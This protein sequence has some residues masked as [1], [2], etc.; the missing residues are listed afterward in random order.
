MAIRTGRDKRRV[1]RAHRM[2]GDHRDR[3]AQHD[4]KDVPRFAPNFTV[5]V[6]PSKVVCLYSED[7]KFFLHGELYCALASAIGEGGKSFRELVREL[8]PDF[9]SDKIHEALKRLVDRRFV[10]AKPRASAD[11]VA[12]Y[13]ASLGL[14][15][16]IA[17]KNLQKCRVRIQSIDV[18]GAAEL[19]AALGGLGV[20]VVQRSADLTV[21]LVS[22]YLEGQLAELN[23]Q[24]LSDRTPWVLVQPCGIF[25]LVGP[26]LSPGKSACWACL[27]E[28]MKRNREIKALLDRGL[29]RRLV[30]S[31]LAR[32]MVG[33]SGIQLAAVEIAKAIA[34]DF[35]TD[36]R[37]H[38][39]S[40]DLLGS[41][42]VKHYVAARPQCP[43]CGR[44]ELRD[45]G[46]A[47]VP[48]ELG[49]GGKLIMTSGGYRAG[50]PAATVA[51]LRKHVSLLTGVVSRLQSI[52]RDGM[53][54]GL[55]SARRTLQISSDQPLVFFLQG[56]CRRPGHRGFQRLRGRQ[57]VR[58]S[59][60]PGI[61][62]AGGTGFIRNLVV[63]SIAAG[64]SGP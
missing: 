5:Y 52:G 34:T 2:T 49:A 38:I 50:S 27:A 61:P 17:E 35:R 53:V 42:I 47:P 15:P 13:W 45:P 33:Q 14:S 3:I 58:G 10:V 30:T 39:I 57:H 8:E 51:R 46:R 26:L 41:T 48:V 40:L 24:H 16:E 59:N 55:V 32:D 21:T 31:P 11:T 36:L 62:R 20:R 54:A 28:R 37:N 4:S 56:P 29:A 7:R 60:R 23:R 64:G 18:Q 22:D 12:A 44:K 6:L 25:P 19:G 43:T 1:A 9:P 63:Q